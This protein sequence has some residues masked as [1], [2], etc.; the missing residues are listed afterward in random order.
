[1]GF[2]ASRYRRNRKKAVRKLPMAPAA[3]P[4]IIS[5]R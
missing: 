1:M 4:V 2:L 5:M 3:I